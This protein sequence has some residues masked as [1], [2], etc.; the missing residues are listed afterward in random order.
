MNPT[1]GPNHPA[2]V[3]GQLTQECLAARVRLRPDVRITAQGEGRPLL[4]EDVIRNRFYEVGM[5]EHSVIRQFD[6]QLAVAEI[7]ART[8]MEETAARQ[9]V[10]AVAEWLVRNNLAYIEGAD[11][12]GRLV[13]RVEQLRTARRL[14]W[15]NLLSIRIPVCR[16]AWLMQ[17]LDGV[18]R[19]LFSRWAFLAWCLLML[20]AGSV[21]WTRWEEFGAGYAGILSGQRWIWAL[22]VWAGLK[23][24]HELGHALA[25]QRY[26][27]EVGEA[28]LLL[29]LF[30]PM[31][32]VDVSSC[33]RFP[34]GWQR[35]VVSAAGMYVELAI[36]AVAV[37]IWGRLDS[38]SAWRQH[39]FDLVLMAS[40]TT[41]LFNANPLMKFDGYFILS[42][43]S[44]IKGLY[45][46]GQ[47]WVREA[48]RSMVLGWPMS[49]PSAEVHERLAVPVYGITSLVWRVTVSIGLLAAASVLFHGAGVLLAIAGGLVWIVVPAWTAWRE[50]RRQAA[51]VPVNRHRLVWS[52]GIIAAAVLLCGVVLQ[53]PTSRS[54]PAVVRL[55]NERVLRA[56]ADGFVRAVLVH[57]GEAV[58]A[59]QE[60][61]RLENHALE[62]EARQLELEL[63]S[64]RIEAR[65]LL[66]RRELAEYQA[67]QEALV[68][69][70]KQMAEAR[71]RLEG[72]TLVAPVDGMVWGRELEN[73]TGQLVRQ[74]TP[75]LAVAPGSSR[76]IVASISQDESASFEAVLN[77]PVKVVFAGLPVTS[78][79]VKMVSPRAELKPVHAALC[80]AAGGPL[81]VKTIARRE[82]GN[83]PGEPE[84]QLLAPRFNVELALPQ[85]LGERVFP[86]QTGQVIFASQQHSLGVWAWLQVRH[87]LRAKIELATQQS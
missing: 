12:S 55:E 57:D 37:L 21:L 77:R 25:C 74:G 87:W 1:Q 73:L 85:E 9:T 44:G 7:A 48:W 65:K 86:G 5:L 56:R 46:R 30:T 26:G 40:V 10:W 84:Y 61:V 75:I 24:V 43:L 11:N 20:S 72:M 76:E 62:F 63:E 41:L 31:A 50:L 23:V 39:C 49:P 66:E 53:S 8:E 29:M 18:A 17:R 83:E 33:W 47:Q 81:P 59:G 68:N 2:G 52:A 32:W 60:L 67:K 80:A 3:A 54:A 71:S 15:L 4:V 45:P 22:L 42:D 35:A 14:G 51:C 38:Q 19:V 6:G 69:L 58:R 78:C 70:Q 82:D 36:A 16:P 27:G 28:G 79:E 13:S 34:S 64:A